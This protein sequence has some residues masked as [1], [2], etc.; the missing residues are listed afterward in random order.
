M[1]DQI[2]EPEGSIRVETGTHGIKAGVTLY[3]VFD[4]DW[5]AQ[6]YDE[7]NS[8]A[9]ARQEFVNEV[10]FALE[11]Q[12]GAARASEQTERPSDSEDRGE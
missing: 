4:G 6:Y 2:L 8:E 1:S 12:K 3:F 10:T 7:H 11:A 9:D 5:S